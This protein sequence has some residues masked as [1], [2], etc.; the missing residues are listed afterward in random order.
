VGDEC[1][2]DPIGQEIKARRRAS[3]EDEQ[4]LMRAK[5][6]RDGSA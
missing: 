5:R 3:G 2:N 4:V 6:V 1:K